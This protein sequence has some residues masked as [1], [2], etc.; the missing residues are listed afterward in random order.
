[1]KY[2]SPRARERHE[3]S[4]VTRQLARF[5]IVA[6]VT[7]SLGACTDASPTA[8]A[9][10]QRPPLDAGA[11]NASA[12]NA[13]ATDRASSVLEWNAIARQLVADERTDP[14]MA[15]R[16]YAL[17]SV[18]Q[19]DALDALDSR[20]TNG[21][22]A[23]RGRAAV[24]AASAVVLA[25]AFPD[26]ASWLLQN[27]DRSVGADSAG[28]AMGT[29]AALRVLQVA[30][31]DRSDLA[32]SGTPPT[33]E[34]LWFSSSVPPASPL[35]PRWGEVRPWL[36][37]SGREFRP[38]PPPRFGSEAYRAALTEVR[39]ISDN[40]TS[41]QLRIAQFWAD[42]AATATPPGHWNAIAS[43][44]IQRYHLDERRAAEVMTR[45]NMA[46]MD[47][48]IA[49]WDA[50][51]T[52]WLI[53]PPQADPLITTPVGLP[54]FPSYVS[55]HAT[56]SGAASEVLASAFP[57]ERKELRSMAEEAAMSRLY[58]GIHYRFDNEVGLRMGRAIARLAIAWR[59]EKQ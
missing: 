54:N 11:P 5:L 43:D 36:M 12:P 27:R 32:W 52:Y 56:F 31:S 15:S 51:Y 13:D 28:A 53:R 50:K 40:R 23:E 45:L 37:S 4:A 16:Y 29:A 9:V 14:P 1:M 58:A 24:A 42:G 20:G 26:R 44:L 41:E 57:A 22:H 7:A 8:P 2:Y 21:S 47:A 3:D 30:R 59:P 6:A 18:A 35:R 17:L 10:D 39:T 25:E 46:L 49:C 38:E 34:G 48:G 19:L 33:G 55:G